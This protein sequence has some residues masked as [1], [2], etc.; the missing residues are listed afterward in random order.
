MKILDKHG[1]FGYK[2]AYSFHFEQIMRIKFKLLCFI[3]ICAVTASLVITKVNISPYSFL[4]SSIEIARSQL[5]TMAHQHQISSSLLDSKLF[6]SNRDRTTASQV[7]TAKAKPER[8]PIPYGFP[9]GWYDSIDYLNTPAKIA[10]EGI[11]AIIPYTGNSNPQKVRAYLDRAAAA[12]IKVVV[13]IPRDAVSRKRTEQIIQFVKELKSHPAT[14]GWYLYDEPVPSRITPTAL[15]QIYQAIKAE[16]PKH[17]IAIAFNR[18]F[19]MVKYFGAFDVALYDKYPAF[20]DSPEFTGFQDGIF[21]KLVETAVSLTQNRSGFWYIIQ[22]Y[23]ENTVGK[24][25]FDRRLP[26]E[27][28]E[29]YMIYTAILNKVDGLFFW[30]HYRSQQQ[31]ID[32]VLTPII[33]E[34]QNYLPAITQKALDRKLAIDNSAIQARIYQA[35]TT[36]DLLLI[37]INHSEGQLE[38]AIAIEDIQAESAKVLSENRLVD[39]SQR[40]L[41]DTFEPYAVH[42]YQL[43]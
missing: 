20:Y 5:W 8:S 26:T 4:G 34:L 41:T 32:S 16:D 9:L 18:L 23:G 33:K 12:N 30:T 13:E 10:D 15:R 38:T 43:E 25:Q 2:F 6:D 14:F 31:W 40:I 7:T 37:A 29:R 42:I 21:K 27:A 36:Q 19:R 24:P 17:T 1:L 22:G 3:F 39:F 28:E 11:N 35:P